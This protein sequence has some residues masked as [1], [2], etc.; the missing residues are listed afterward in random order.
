MMKPPPGTSRNKGTQNIRGGKSIQ[1]TPVSTSGSPLP[2]SPLYASR[3]GIARIRSPIA[4]R[5]SSSTTT[6]GDAQGIWM[7]T[8]TP[9]KF[10]QF[11]NK[12]FR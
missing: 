11:Q 2:S 8:A 9:G 10:P 5:S 4:L 1:A 6:E 7:E 12:I 3:A